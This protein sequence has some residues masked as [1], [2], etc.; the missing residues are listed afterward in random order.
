MHK[1]IQFKQMPRCL[2]D[3]DKKWNTA[4]EHSLSHELGARLCFSSFVQL[5]RHQV[6]L[7][8]ALLQELALSRQTQAAQALP[9]KS[10][11]ST[12]IQCSG[13]RTRQLKHWDYEP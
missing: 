11:H 12:A 8:T 6:A 7:S 4:A 13:R 5:L 3:I 9:E 2:S 10:S 1:P